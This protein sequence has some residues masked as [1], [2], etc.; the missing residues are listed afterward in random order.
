LERQ[1]HAALVEAR[2]SLARR[3]VLLEGREDE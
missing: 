1:L 3:G 2:E